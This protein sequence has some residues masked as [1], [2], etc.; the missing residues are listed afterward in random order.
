MEGE[1]A[2]PRLETKVRLYSDVRGNSELL[3]FAELTIARAFVIKD[4]RIVRTRGN[5]AP[6]EPFVSFPSKRKTGRDGGEEYVD[7]AHPITTQA[8]RIAKET[9]LKAYE[10]AAAS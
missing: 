7:V 3:A 5:G 10:H 1:G 6:G 8:Y 4:I 9:I 2:L